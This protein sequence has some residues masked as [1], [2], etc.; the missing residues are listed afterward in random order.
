MTV[1]QALYTVKKS[2]PTEERSDQI[3]RGLWILGESAGS[4]R[5]QPAKADHKLTGGVLRKEIRLTG[6][7]AGQLRDAGCYRTP[8]QSSGHNF[9]VAAP[10]VPAQRTKFKGIVRAAAQLG[11]EDLRCPLPPIGT[12]AA[13]EEDIRDQLSVPEEI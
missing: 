5:R 2:G 4:I 3:G 1:A 12:R 13:V 9:K 8:G 7:R 10:Q 6:S 11:I